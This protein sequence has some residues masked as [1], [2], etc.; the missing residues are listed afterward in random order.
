MKLIIDF[1]LD[2]SNEFLALSI[3]LRHFKKRGSLDNN[4]DFISIVNKLTNS[5]LKL[6][7]LKL[8]HSLNNFNVRFYFCFFFYIIFYNFKK[9]NSILK[10][11]F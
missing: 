7:F 10:Q 5:Y 11:I 6:L 4:E 3:I 1:N 2:K 9:Q 8:S